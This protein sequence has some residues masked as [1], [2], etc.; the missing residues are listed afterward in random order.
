M[1]NLAPVLV[2]AVIFW[3]IVMMLRTVS[4]NKLRHKL[5]EKGMVDKSYQTL[6]QKQEEPVVSSSLKWGMILIAMGLALVISRT[7]L[8]DYSEEVTFGFMSLF[9]GL[10][11]LAYYL[12][13]AR[14]ANKKK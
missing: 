5:V 3:G 10:A 6:F 11:L 9:V 13:A 1:G 7:F 8:H 12:I 2:L 14:M 4:D